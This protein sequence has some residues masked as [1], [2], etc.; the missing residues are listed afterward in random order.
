MCLNSAMSKSPDPIANLIIDGLGGTGVVAELCE[1][2]DAAVSQWR[3][4]SIPKPRVKFLR[5]ARPDFDWT[6]VPVGYPAR[7][8][9]AAGDIQHD[10]PSPHEEGV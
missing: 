1:V 9:V 10:E 5:L 2:S 8:V 3:T 6:P 4:E 7:R